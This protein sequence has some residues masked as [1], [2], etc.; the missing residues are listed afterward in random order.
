MVDLKD[1]L[2]YSQYL[3]VLSDYLKSTIDISLKCRRFKSS[4]LFILKVLLIWWKKRSYSTTYIAPLV[5]TRGE[6]ATTTQSA[7]WRGAI[8]Q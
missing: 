7:H 4:S 1:Y 2:S 8:E 3:R 5:P 6:L